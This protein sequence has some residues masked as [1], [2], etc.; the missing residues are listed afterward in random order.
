MEDEEDD[1]GVRASLRAMLV[2]LQGIDNVTEAKTDAVEGERRRPREGDDLHGLAEVLAGERYISHD[3]GDV[4]LL[5]ACGLAEILRICAPDPPISA[6]K[7]NEVCSLFIEQLAVMASP[8]DSMETHRFSL[9]EQLATVKTFV[10]FCDE[11]EIVCDLFAC[12]YAIARPHQPAKVGQYFSDIL[13]SLV[14]EAE[15][16]SYAMLDAMIAPL[17]PG[18]EYSQ[19]AVALAE[20]V[21]RSC[22]NAV[23][24]EL[25]SMLNASIRQLR[26]SHSSHTPEKPTRRRTPVKRKGRADAEADSGELSIHHDS[27]PDLLVAVNRVA[28][29]I[30]I[31]VIPSLE[32]RIRSPDIDVR[33]ANVHL[34]ARLFT[35]RN[36]MTETYPSLFQGFLARIRDVSPD[37][38]AE[39]CAVMGEL[40][41]SH[42]NLRLDL[43]KQLRD[44]ALDREEAVRVVAVRSIGAAVD[45]ASPETLKLLATRLRDRKPNVR[46]AALAQLTG[47]YDG[48]GDG[49]T[50]QRTI[51]EGNTLSPATFVRDDD[52]S[53][54]GSDIVPSRQGASAAADGTNMDG[55]MI[56]SRLQRLDWLPDTLIQSTTALRA[57][58]DYSTS[59][60]I[61]QVIFERI[62]KCKS[63]DVQVARSRLRRF[64]TFLANLNDA[65]F[66]Q[67]TVLVQER[68]KASDILMA[69]VKQRFESRKPTNSVPIDSNEDEVEGGERDTSKFSK[70]RRRSDRSDTF[71]PTPS[72]QEQLQLCAKALSRYFVGRAGSVAVVQGLCLLVATA[73]DFRIFERIARAIDGT[74]TYAERRAAQQDAVARLG[75]RSAAGLFMQDHVF[76]KCQ[77]G[78]FSSLHFAAACNLSVDE[79]NQVCIVDADEEGASPSSYDERSTVLCGVLRYLEVACR[80][81]NPVLGDNVKSICSMVATPLEP[82]NSSAEVILAGLKLITNLPDTLRNSGDVQDLRKSFENLI[83]CE[84]LFDVEQGTKLVKWASRAMIWLSSSATC[85]ASLLTDVVKS[86]ARQINVFSGDTESLVG[87][88][89]ALSQYAKHS[90]SVF[91]PVALEAFDFSK[92]LLCGSYNSKISSALKGNRV[93]S[94]SNR[95]RSQSLAR[96]SSIP[97]ALADD[98]F[99]LPDRLSDKRASCLAELVHRAVKL[100]VY[101]LE[102]LDQSDD[103]LNSVFETL[104]NIILGKNGDVFGLSENDVEESEEDDEEYKPESDSIRTVCALSRLFA[105]RGILY[106]ARHPKFF[107]NVS[108]PIMISTLLLAQDENPDIRITFAKAISNQ[109]LKK[110]LPF[111]WVVALPLMAVDPVRENLMKVRNF[112]ASLLR[113]RRKVF[114]RAK[115]EGRSGSMQLLPESAI[116][117]LIWVLANL[118]DVEA[119]REAGFLESQKCLE[120]L[121]E[122][123]LESNDYA[124]I[125]NEYIGSLSISQDA[126]ESQDEGPG[127]KTDRIHELSRIAGAILKTKQ[128][129]RK[130]NLVEHVG[131]V[132][133]PKDMFRLMDRNVDTS[134]IPP[135]SLLEVAR[136]FDDDKLGSIHKKERPTDARNVDI[137]STPR[138]P[139][140]QSTTKGSGIYMAPDEILR[141][142]PLLLKLD[143]DGIHMNMSDDMLVSPES[144]EKPG[145]KRRP[146]EFDIGSPK[147]P[148]RKSL[149]VEGARS[150]EN[151]SSGLGESGRDKQ[152]QHGEASVLNIASSPLNLDNREKK[153]TSE[154]LEEVTPQPAKKLKITGNVIPESEKENIPEE[155]EDRKELRPVAG[156]SVTPLTEPGK[157]DRS[158]G[159][160]ARPAGELSLQQND[161]NLEP[162]ADEEHAQRTRPRSQRS[163]KKPEKLHTATVKLSQKTKADSREV[164][165]VRRS[166]RNRRR[167]QL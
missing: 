75:S 158:E 130:W 42:A 19:S 92:A 65:N 52:S 112:L 56:E 125:L 157:A 41:V 147:L 8:K 105:G 86:S 37:I 5:A 91:K 160:G 79:S 138:T 154:E 43:D 162:L 48:T 32:D 4:R 14:D 59:E 94:L 27:I 146:S 141:T 126:T 116:P 39:V 110:R 63:D 53:S 29:D 148:R 166:S 123:L 11:D 161:T 165:V 163:K 9:L 28:S 80:F 100:M 16:R 57:A 119:D 3:C 25:C 55:E 60:E 68:R 46:T 111:R 83:H 156:K 24:V 51:A 40:M 101:A 159:D 99:R 64:A 135:T 13:A 44:G 152:R 73:P 153:R 102:S 129:G 71:A 134:G 12:F 149:R 30:L 85:S 69:I 74:C 20:H 58:S 142:P 77:P 104:L 45:V 34:L 145:G 139:K 78:P 93:G 15:E 21:L 97:S 144:S 95:R 50:T 23:Q 113:H 106:L 143:H 127:E 87:P 121:L 49:R 72:D 7:L 167:K 81:A 131:N 117:D 2:R 132:L 31:Y 84:T 108:P 151:G 118:P 88:V 96:R 47:I 18:L 115:L 54:F 1:E 90:A 103:E 114:E 33:L 38:R 109:I 164:P 22:A 67:F 6:R 62:P 76:P 136:R 128:A 17:V 150:V 36:D 70:R 124:G 61:E 107:R 140:G 10:I 35:S 66:A 82:S 155:P 137:F 89:T 98:D 133:L 26:Q 120:M 122:R